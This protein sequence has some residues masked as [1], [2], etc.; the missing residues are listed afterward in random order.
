MGSKKI[1]FTTVHSP[2]HHLEGHPENA[3][4]FKH[5]RHLEDL[6]TSAEILEITPQPADEGSI[7]KIHPAQY[8]EALKQATQ[9]GPGFVDYGDTY[10]TPASY[11]AAFM[12]VGGVLEVLDAILDGRAVAGYALVRPPGHHTTHTKAMGFC[13]LNN[14][15]VAARVAQAHGHSKMCICQ[16]S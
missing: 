3:N 12:A 13:L 9:M 4:R 16:H 11:E 14:I 15:A 2:D 6:P 1:G 10:V 8:L 5:F 7:L